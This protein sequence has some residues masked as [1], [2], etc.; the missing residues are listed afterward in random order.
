MRFKY[1]NIAGLNV[2]VIN[3]GQKKNVVLLHGY[4]ANAEDLASLTQV[5]TLDDI[6]WIFPEAPLKLDFFPGMASFT[7]FPLD[8]T[9][10]REL[11]NIPI[12]QTDRFEPEGL[13]EASTHVRRLVKALGLDPAQTAIGGFSQ[14]AMVATNVALDS[15]KSY[16]AI[17]IM[18]GTLICREK[19]VQSASR[20]AAT[21]YFLSHGNWDERLPAEKARNLAGLLKE[22]GLHGEEH[23]FGGGHEIPYEIIASLRSFLEKAFS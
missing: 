16:A 6:T 8:E 2:I 13:G 3:P 17:L 11:R 1:E 14:G 5:L 15:T 19:W 4:G 21:Q 10:L 7:W 23:F 9:R 20:H 12:E 18:S 22:G